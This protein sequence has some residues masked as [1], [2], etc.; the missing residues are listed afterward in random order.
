MEDKNLKKFLTWLLIFCTLP[1]YSVLANEAEQPY[2]L[3]EKFLYQIQAGSGFS[4]LAEL[5]YQ[6]GDNE[7]LSKVLNLQYIRFIENNS[8]IQQLTLAQ[9]DNS[10]LLVATL[11]NDALQLQSDLIG[12]DAYLFSMDTLSPKIQYDTDVFFEQTTIP[13]LAKFIASNSITGFKHFSLLPH[14][15]S[16]RTSVD[17]WLEKYREK[18]DISKDENGNTCMHSTYR[19]TAKQIKEDVAFMLANLMNDELLFNSLLSSL[20]TDLAQLML[21]PQFFD[22]ANY[23]LTNLPLSSDFTLEIRKNDQNELDFLTL[24]MPLYDAKTGE[25]IITFHQEFLKETKQNKY[26]ITLKNDDKQVVINALKTE[27][28]TQPTKWEGTVKINS[29]EDKPILFG[30][31]LSTHTRK[32]INIHNDSVFYQDFSI[33]LDNKPV[34]DSFNPFFTFTYDSFLTSSKEENSPTTYNT[35]ISI[36]HNEN[37][38][39]LK[40]DGKTTSPWLT[41]EFDNV[42]VYNELHEDEQNRILFTITEHLSNFWGIT[43]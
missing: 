1:I 41:K 5:T 2:N 23:A 29:K 39:S 38:Y 32:S 24:T 3:S 42:H 18:T 20:P 31:Q 34:K 13:T 7:P 6:N 22:Y 40:L 30:Y 15:D 9:Q 27:K 36:K 37:N 26:T 19:I 12:K 14:I 43:Q 17:M 10:N 28:N 21:Q 4:G 16:M 35:T 25:T 8:T 33:S 11:N